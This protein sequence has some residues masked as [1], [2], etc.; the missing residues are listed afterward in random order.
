MET[1]RRDAGRVLGWEFLESVLLCC[2]LWVTKP[3]IE[4]DKGGRIPGNRAW[5]LMTDTGPCFLD[6]LPDI[7]HLCPYLNLHTEAF[8][9]DQPPPSPSTPCAELLGNI[10]IFPWSMFF[11]KSFH[12][13]RKDHK[14]NL[15]LAPCPK[16]STFIILSFVEYSLCSI[17]S[18]LKS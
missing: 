6:T 8:P 3:F 1:P 13:L 5:A 11:G 2:S 18:G 16:F 15:E 7:S 17:H 12:Y 4:E 10:L 14:A 9:V